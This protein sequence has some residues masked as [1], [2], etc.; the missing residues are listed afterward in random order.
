MVQL[1][2]RFLQGNHMPLW[3]VIMFVVCFIILLL[4]SGFIKGIFSHLHVFMVC[5]ILLFLVKNIK[6]FFFFKILC[7]RCLLLSFLPYIVLH[8]AWLTECLTQHPCGHSNT[9]DA[10]SSLNQSRIIWWANIPFFWSENLHSSI[11]W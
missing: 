7:T 9:A 11:N 1:G 10:F 2:N 4:L 5:R 6:V 8:E 3:V